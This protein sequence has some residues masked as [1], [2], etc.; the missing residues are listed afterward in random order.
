MIEVPI[1]TTTVSEPSARSKSDHI[2][3]SSA[4]NTSRKPLRKVILARLFELGHGLFCMP[5][6]MGRRWVDGV[7]VEG[8]DSQLSLPW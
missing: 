7:Q 5:C 8:R 2:T 6:W 1:I 3:V 4:R